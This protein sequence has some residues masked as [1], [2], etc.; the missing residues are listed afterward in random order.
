MGKAKKKKEKKKQQAA[1]TKSG[2]STVAVNR[3]AGFDYKLGDDVIAGIELT[4]TEVKSLR[5]GQANLKGSYAKIIND[6][7]F[8]MNCHISEYKF[9]NRNN[10]D[11]WRVR[12]LLLH[13][14]EIEWL[15]KELQLKKLTL[16]ATKIF[17]KGNWAKVKLALAEGKKHSDKRSDLKK[18]A[19]E[20]DIQQALKRYNG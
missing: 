20:R 6:E 16:V 12:K 17:F 10:H 18:K 7:I 13:K 14:S 15:E 5:N 9:G 3:K 8:L 1:Q 4:G 19:Q 2:K 11:P